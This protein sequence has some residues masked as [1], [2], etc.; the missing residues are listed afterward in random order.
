MQ[1]LVLLVNHAT[2]KTL[3]EFD[4]YISTSPGKLTCDAAG[5][6]SISRLVPKMFKTAGGLG[7]RRRHPPI[8]V[9]VRMASGSGPADR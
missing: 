8:Y 9:T 5:N 2:A 6:G 1:P 4:S 3:Q 7:A